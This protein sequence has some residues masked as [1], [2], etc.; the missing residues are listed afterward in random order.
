ME[1]Y[2]RILILL[3]AIAIAISVVVRSRPGRDNPAPVASGVLSARSGYV[4]VS[5]DVRHPGCYPVFAKILTN[6]VISMADPLRPITI[7]QPPTAGSVVLAS[8]DS[9]HL[10]VH[11]DGSTVVSRE[12]IPAAQRLILGIPLD[13]NTISETDL[14]KVPGIGP[15]LAGRIIRYR[16]NNGGLMTVGELEQIEGIGAKKFA[17]LQKYFQAADIR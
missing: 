15:G 1:R 13:I 8:G 10:T 14:D 17:G 12:A 2:R 4:Q 9:L 7:L 16:Q 3:L 6:D 5:G 11:A